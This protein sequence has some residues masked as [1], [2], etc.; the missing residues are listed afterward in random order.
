M[1]IGVALEKVVPKNLAATTVVVVAATELSIAALIAV[2]WYPR[3]VG[4]VSALVFLCFG[5]YKFA[6][7]VRTGNVSC[8][9]SGVGRTYRATTA[10]VTAAVV[11]SLVQAGL[12]SVWIFAPGGTGEAFKL[13]GILAISIPLAIFFTGLYSRDPSRDS[14]LVDMPSSA[15]MRVPSTTAR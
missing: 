8:N 14:T 1:V 3:V 6:V 15:A 10:A 7:S 13:A 2:D 4:S 12:A 9:C 11:A 5:G